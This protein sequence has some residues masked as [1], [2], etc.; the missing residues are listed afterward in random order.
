MRAY[1]GGHDR[2][3][4]EYFFYLEMDDDLK[5]YLVT[6]TITRSGVQGSG[7]IPLENASGHRGYGKAIEFI[8]S[9]LF[10]APDVRSDAP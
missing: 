10:E 3:G 4:D 2:Q 8:K 9:R 6:E 7:R 5:F 1:L